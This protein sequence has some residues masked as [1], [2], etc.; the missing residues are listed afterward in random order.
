M[1]DYFLG[2]VFVFLVALPHQMTMTL[3]HMG[4]VTYRCVRFP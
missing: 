2:F 1:I 4:G 3:Y